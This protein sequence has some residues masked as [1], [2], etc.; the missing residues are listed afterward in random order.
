MNNKKYFQ[1]A[2]WATLH[3]RTC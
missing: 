2:N 1:T 3:G